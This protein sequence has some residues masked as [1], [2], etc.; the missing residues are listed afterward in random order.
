MDESKDVFIKFYSPS[1]PHCIEI[2]PAWEELGK[3]FSDN[4]DLIIAD[5]D[6]ASNELPNF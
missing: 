4:E 6:G 2:A 1:C 3:N 5:F